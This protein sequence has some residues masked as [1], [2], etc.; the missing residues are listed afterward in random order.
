LAGNAVI[1]G[2]GVNAVEA[3][4]AIKPSHL[5]AASKMTSSGGNSFRDGETTRPWRPKVDLA[6]W[7]K[8]RRYRRIA[9]FANDE[10]VARQAKRAVR[11]GEDKIRGDK[12]ETSAGKTAAED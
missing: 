2:C 9:T 7:E 4:R 5:V 11:L 12:R 10:E 3:K 8:V 6:L 1:A